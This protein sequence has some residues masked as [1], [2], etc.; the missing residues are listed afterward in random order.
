MPRPSVVKAGTFLRDGTVVCDVRI[1]RVPF[2]PGS[3]DSE[4][5]PEDRDDQPGM[6]FHVEYGSTAQ[7]G[8]FNAGDGYHRTV[9]A[10]EAEITKSLGAVEW[11]PGI[12]PAGPE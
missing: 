3:G 11:S 7:R 5:P 6:W 1:A 4:D 2:R 12:R 9:E 8:I 10:A